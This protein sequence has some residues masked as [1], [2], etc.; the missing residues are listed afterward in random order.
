MQ[1]L[2]PMFTFLKSQAYDR[3]LAIQS[4]YQQK[5]FGHTRK[6]LAL[7]TSVLRQEKSQH[8]QRNS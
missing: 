7:I 3:V 2:S 1:G 4:T 5:A 8:E 6:C